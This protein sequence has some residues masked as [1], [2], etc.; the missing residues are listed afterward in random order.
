MGAAYEA[1]FIIPYNANK[2]LTDDGWEFDSLNKL[3][4]E[5]IDKLITSLELKLIEK[6]EG[7][8]V[9]SSNG[10]KVS[11][12]HDST[13]SIEYVFC[14]VFDLLNNQTISEFCSNDSSLE[15]FKPA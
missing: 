10:I 2:R 1:I 12:F 8:S 9:Y 15:F 11:V 14:Q 6:Y 3:P 7:V 5:K 4:A 13:G